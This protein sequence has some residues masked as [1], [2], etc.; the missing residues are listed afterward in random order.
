MCSTCGCNYPN[1]DHPMANAKG[2]NS[3]D[4]IKPMPSSIVKATPKKPKK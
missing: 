1:I 3:M 4:V 2:D